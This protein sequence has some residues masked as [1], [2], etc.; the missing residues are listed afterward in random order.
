MIAAIALAVIAYIQSQSF[1]AT[2]N[3]TDLEGLALQATPTPQLD[4]QGEVIPPAETSDQPLP[5]PDSSGPQAKPW[6]GASPI[7][8]LV[9]GLDYGDWSADR[10]GPSRTDTMILFTLDPLTM[11]AGILNIPRD[12]WV[13]IPGFENARINTAY[14]LGEANQLPG[15]GPALAIKT[16]EQLMGVPINYYAQVDFFAFVKFIDIIGGVRIDVPAEIK[17]DPIGEGN[18]ITLTPGIHHLYGDE[19]LAYARARYTDGGD[20]DRAQRQQQVIMEIRRRVFKPEL[21][22]LLLSKAPEIYRELAGGIRTNMTFDEA[23]QF[24]L[25]LKDITTENIRRAAIAPPDQVLFAKSPDGTQDILKPIPDKIRET[26]DFIFGTAIKPLAQTADPTADPAALM[27]QEAARIT[28]LNGTWVEG[29]ATTTQNYLNSQGANVVDVGNA[30]EQ[31]SESKI[32]DYT[33]NP[34]TLRYL[35]EVFGVPPTNIYSQYDPASTTDVAIVL[36]ATWA[37][38]NPLP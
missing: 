17:I 32:Y 11:T 21:F 9:M 6:D 13:S 20:F 7:T 24:G 29:L 16:V 30:G 5:A 25:L 37:N 38:S 14:Y 23:L 31:P 26:R 19:A 34:Y 33:G 27:Q 4:A 12:L 28:V 2:Y 35:V 36:G 3:V 10:E 15:G 18:T 8:V 22:P 1:F